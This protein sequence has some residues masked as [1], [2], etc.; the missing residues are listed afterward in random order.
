MSLF[1]QKLTFVG[2]RM[3]V[4]IV[5]ENLMLRTDVEVMPSL[6]QKTGL[7]VDPVELF[8]QVTT[9]LWVNKTFSNCQSLTLSLPERAPAKGEQVVGF[10]EV[11]ISR[12][13]AQLARYPANCLA[14][15]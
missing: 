11:R 12:L 3:P 14:V 4:A 2:R 8:V 13:P 10:L 5:G 15:F 9:Q 6:R 7:V 1:E